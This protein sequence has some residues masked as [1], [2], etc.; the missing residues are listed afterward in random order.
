MG[1]YEFCLVRFLSEKDVKTIYFSQVNSCCMDKNTIKN[2]AA[3]LFNC[4]TYNDVEFEW[5]KSIPLGQ[6]PY[7]WSNI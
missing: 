5:L 6:I 1:A 3:D 7:N 4:L 2:K